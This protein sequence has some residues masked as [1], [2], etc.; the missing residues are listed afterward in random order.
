MKYSYN[1]RELNVTELPTEQVLIDYMHNNKGFKM[2]SV[3]DQY[4]LSLKSYPLTSPI[5]GL[6]DGEVAEENVHFK[7]L[8]ET[9]LKN[10]EWMY[11]NERDYVHI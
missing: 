6:K 1:E 3:Y 4:I 9:L 5:K 10:G 2:V 7:I 11:I 8:H